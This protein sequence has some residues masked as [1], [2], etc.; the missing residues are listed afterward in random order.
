MHRLL[1]VLALAGAC[2]APPRPATKADEPPT[3]AHPLAPAPA[4]TPTPAEPAPTLGAPYHRPGDRAA[5]VDGLTFWGWSADGRR[6]AFETAF[7]GAGGAACEGEVDLYIVDAERDHFV[8]GGH[9]EVK[10]TSPDAEPCDPPDLQAAMDARRPAL[11]AAHGVV[12]GNLRA[13]VAPLS[14]GDGR[15]DI[16]MLNLPSGKLANLDIDVL[17]GDR[18]RA[19]EAQGAAFKLTLEVLGHPPLVVEAGTRRRPH[20]WDY[21]PG[22]GLAFFSPDGRHAAILTAAIALSYEGDRTSF[23]ANGLRLPDGF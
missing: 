16:F 15:N 23:I 5:Q 14:V 7:A 1:C 3:P 2:T 6:F 22:R 12:V 21:D 4:P 11:L 10:H 19:H 20:V 18:E 13:P 8:E 17:Y 9:V